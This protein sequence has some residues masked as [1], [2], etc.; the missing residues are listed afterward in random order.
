MS[1]YRVL[2]IAAWTTGALLLTTWAGIKGWSGHASQEGLDAMHEAREQRAIV[3]A[4]NTASQTTTFEPVALN[5]LT[6]ASPD[7]SDWNQKRLTEYQK[8]L[9]SKAMPAAVLRIPK[10]KLEVPVYEG[11]SDLTLNRGA[12]LIP[13]TADVMSSSGN[14][15]IAAHRDGFFRPLKDIQLGDELLVDTVSTTRHY[16]VTRM[17]IV[18]PSDV[19]VLKP[20]AESTITLVTCYPFYFIGSAPKRFIVQ[21]QIERQGL[22][23]D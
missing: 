21:A 19:S 8:S 5:A 16:R 14:V 23:K 2:E 22:A 18:D 13:G 7:T 9:S 6:T 11:T 1:I 10:F 20:T 12:G 3:V 15:G 4:E 17:V